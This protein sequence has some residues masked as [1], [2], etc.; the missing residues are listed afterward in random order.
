MNNL[1]YVYSYT[2][3]RNNEVFYIG[4]GTKYRKFSHLNISLNYIKNGID[5]ADTLK[6]KKYTKII[7]ILKSG[8]EPVIE[9]IKD[10]LIEADAFK[11]ESELILFYGRKDLCN[12]TLLNLT[13]GDNPIHPEFFSTSSIYR[14]ESKKLYYESE[15]GKLNKKYLSELYKNKKVGSPEEWLGESRGKELRKIRSTNARNNEKFMHQDIR[16]EKNPFFGKHH[17][18]ETRKII[19][20]KRKGKKSS[21]STRK[22]ISEGGKKRHAENQLKKVPEYEVILPNG[23]IE[24][25][26]SND[27]CNY[28]RNH[29]MGVTIINDLI[30]GKRKSYNGYT[31]TKIKNESN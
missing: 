18:E 20:E 24:Y 17:T 19:S 15:Q 12:G 28:A 9:I 4:K 29:R 7:E 6:N 11:L 14:S 21:E 3:P 27:K 5:V 10:N 1:F 31:L 13:N 23:E 26:L 8:N 16:G 30:S 2:D 25:I 22:K